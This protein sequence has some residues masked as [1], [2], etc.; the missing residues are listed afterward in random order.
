MIPIKSFK[1]L[2]DIIDTSF[3]RTQICRAAA[4]KEKRP[5]VHKVL[6]QL[7]QCT[8]E[9]TEN[10]LRQK[11]QLHP[12]LKKEL[13]DPHS[14]KTRQLQIPLFYPDHIYCWCFVQMFMPVFRRG[15]YQHV[16]SSI[17]GR[18]LDR[19]LKVVQH[20]IQTDLYNTQYVCEMDVHKFYAS[21][22]QTILTTQLER[23]CHDQKAL[24]LAQQL[25]SS[26]PS[27]LPIGDYP[28][29]WFANFY[30]QGLDHFIKEECH[31]PY[32]QRYMDNLILFS[33]NKEHLH[34]SYRRIEEYAHE[35]LHLQFGRNHQIYP[36][37]R[38][39]DYLGLVFYP[40]HTLLRARNFLAFTRQAR[41][42]CWR[43]DNN[44]EIS[45]HETL[46]IS[47]RLAMVRRCNSYNIIN[48][49]LPPEYEM[50]LRRICGKMMSRH[51]KQKQQ[52]QQQRYQ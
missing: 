43:I 46:S 9:I 34:S 44:E 30:L 51:M 12:H 11:I 16:Y 26:V 48:K 36:L 5:Y 3:V 25:I 19:A 45:L 49:Y 24:W 15:M 52:Q 28:S 47:C 42:L 6:Q 2:Y 22:D 23:I 37:T 40:T 4:H 41:D 17:P 20:W 39:L 13:Y 29:P 8:E 10:L 21:V 27:G 38:G 32:Y 50:E 35:R 7:D 14:K 31:I 33:S 18:G 1:H